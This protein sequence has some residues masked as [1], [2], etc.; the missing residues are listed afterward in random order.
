METTMTVT[1]AYTTFTKY[2]D[3]IIDNG[4]SNTITID[5]CTFTEWRAAGQAFW[6]DN[7]ITWGSFTNNTWTHSG[8][9]S[10]GIRFDSAYA[11]FDNIDLS[12]CNF[13]S[14]TPYDVKAHGVKL[15]F[16]NSNFDFTNVSTSSGGTVISKDHND[17]TDLY[18]IET[19][20]SFAYSTVLMSLVLMQMLN[21]V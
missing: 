6:A 12:G 17:T 3:F 8:T 4:S 16:T 20:S 19:D 11:A 14:G 13:A 5:N 9:P 2:H 1:A 10:T 15:E 21:Y 18:E 7:P